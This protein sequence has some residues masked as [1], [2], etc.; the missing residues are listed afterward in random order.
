[1]DD[2]VPVDVDFLAGEA[3]VVDFVLVE[4]VEGSRTAVKDAPEFIF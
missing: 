4:G 1:M 3:L 2:S